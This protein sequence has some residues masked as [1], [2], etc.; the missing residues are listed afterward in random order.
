MIGH[1]TSDRRRLESSYDRVAGLY[2]EK[3][4]DELAHKPLD[5]E[6]LDR[7]ADAVRGSGPVC[8]LGCG[9]GQ[10]ARY[11]RERGVDAFGIDLSSAMVET[12]QRLAPEIS[13]SQGDMAALDAA[14]ASWAGIVAFYSIIHTPRDEMVPVLREL[15]RV[16]QPDGVL[17]LG[18][19]LGNEDL[20]IEE[21][22]GQPVCI[23]MLFFERA[24]MEGYLTRAGLEICDAIERDPYPD[25]EYKS[26]RA[27]IFARRPAGR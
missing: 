25:V 3:Y 1:V 12:A 14:D 10:I 22:S 16:L 7:F 23:D 9:P 17:L 15:R 18:F 8:D 5:R 4:T 2:T 6:L 26:R 20:H 27:Y 24:E 11:L 19:H 13:F 21:W